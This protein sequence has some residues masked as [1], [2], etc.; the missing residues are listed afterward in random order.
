M[1]KILTILL[2]R[3]DSP[4]C[5]I[6]NANKIK[7]TLTYSQNDIQFFSEAASSLG[8]KYAK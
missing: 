7:N 3:P 8:G 5:W 6:E 2:L 1:N 4:E